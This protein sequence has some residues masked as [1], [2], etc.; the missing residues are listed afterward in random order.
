FAT[1]NDSPEM[2][3]LSWEFES[4]PVSFVEDEYS[5]LKPTSLLTIDST[6][7]LV[8]QALL[9]DLLD[10]VQG[11]DVDDPRMPTPDEVLAAMGG[12]GLTDVDLVEET[13]Q[14]TYDGS[15]H[16]VTL[17]TVTG[18]QW[19]IN[20]VNKAPGAQPALTAGQTAT[21]TAVATSGNNIVGDDTWTFK[22]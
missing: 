9:A 12:T 15:T 3:A 1:V 4:N 14:P 21:V 17:P 10:I 18:V 5:D 8:D 13:N 20:G 22:Y 2:T 11:T 7:P 6:S 16:V 19:K